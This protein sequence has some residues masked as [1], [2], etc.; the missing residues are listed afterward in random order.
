[1]RQIFAALLLT[2]LAL[3]SGYGQG[4]STPSPRPLPTP[5]PAEKTTAQSSFDSRNIFQRIFGARPTPTP[6]PAPTPTPAV[7]RA[8]PKPKPG[9]EAPDEPVKKSAPRTSTTTKVAPVPTVPAAPAVPATAK[10][11]G[12]KGTAKKGMPAVPANADDATKFRAAKSQA[13]E[14]AHIKELKNKADSEVNEA[15]AHK[16]LTNY[17][18]ALFQ[19]IREVDPSVSDYSG[20]V[21]Q[22][23]N[24]RIGSEKRSSPPSQTAAPEVSA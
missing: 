6:A 17:N 14:D 18:R 20:K 15:E 19:K 1:M 2:S 16:A 7:K 22:S 5:K 13:M 10:P 21:E 23:M 4:N 24:K 12:G 11:K 8:R 3:P 9:P